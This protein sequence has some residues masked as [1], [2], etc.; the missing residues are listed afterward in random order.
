M[1]RLYRYISARRL[2]QS[3]PQNKRYMR[4]YTRQTPLISNAVTRFDIALHSQ[5]DTYRLPTLPS[6]RIH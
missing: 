4:V 5:N 1:I 6:S 3:P 2:L